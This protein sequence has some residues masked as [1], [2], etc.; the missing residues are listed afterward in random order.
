MY[1]QYFL[2]IIFSVL[3]SNAVIGQ[4]ASNVGAKA[5][6]VPDGYSC[7]IGTAADDLHPF[8]KS[9]ILWPSEERISKHKKDLN[10]SNVQKAIASTYDWL[11]KVLRLEWVPENLSTIDVLALKADVTGNE[12]TDGQGYDVIRLRYKVEN[13]LVEVASTVSMLTLVIQKDR[14]K[15]PPVGLNEESAKIFVSVMIDQFFQ[16][17]DKIKSISFKSIE[18]GKAGYKGRPDTKPETFNVWWGLV[19]WWTDG[20]TVTFSMRKADGGPLM[21]TP[22]KDWF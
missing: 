4:N 7:N 14:D 8:I 21:R 19:Y 11:K 5:E 9:H 12:D 6:K 13:Y 17:S 22:K 20:H 16:N 2:L 10:D 15:N 1:K 18:K 3:S